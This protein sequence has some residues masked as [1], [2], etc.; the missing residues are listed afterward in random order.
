MNSRERFL[1]VMNFEKPD[2]VPLWAFV[3]IMMPLPN[4]LMENWGFHN[5]SMTTDG[6]LQFKQFCEHFGLERAEDPPINLGMVP[7]FKRKVLEDKGE[8]EIIQNEEGIILEQIKPN[9]EA[10]S[11]PHYLKYPVSDRKDW[12]D[13]K[14]RLEYNFEERYPKNWDNWVKKYKDRDYAL[15]VNLKGFFLI[16][17]EWLGPVRLLTIYYDD[18]KLIKDMNEHYVNFLIQSLEKCFREVDVDCVVLGEDMS[19]RSGSMISPEIFRKFMAP[20]YKKFTNFCRENG[21]KNILVDSDGDIMELIPLFMESGV[22][23][24]VSF[25]CGA[26]MDIRKVRSEFP[27]LQI[28]G[29][30]NKYMLE[31]GKTFDDIDKELDSKVPNLFKYGGFLPALD[32]AI[33]PQALLKNW[34]Y[35]LQKL[36]KMCKIKF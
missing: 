3:G 18:P 34:E 25:D 4:V 17:R 26:G 30:L 1:S 21:V 12:E 2:Y 36:R 14:E 27:N 6:D 24:F 13:I 16:A 35:Y 8:R 20:Y 11:M 32:H 7:P 23:G 15:E 19:Y 33:T 22:T 29:G 5:W 28:F 9:I 31:S 10:Y